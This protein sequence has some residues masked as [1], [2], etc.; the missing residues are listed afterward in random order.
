M[1]P[2]RIAHVLNNE[3]ILVLLYARPGGQKTIPNILE[4]MKAPKKYINK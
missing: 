4:V 2:N 1:L 3:I